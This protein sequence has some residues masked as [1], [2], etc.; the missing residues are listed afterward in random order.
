MRIGHLIEQQQ[1]TVGLLVQ[2]FAQPDVG[3]GIDV[4]DHALMRRV[5]RDNPAEIGDIAD[6]NRDIIRDFQRCESLAGDRYLLD[7]PVG[8]VERCFY[9]VPSPEFES[10]TGFLN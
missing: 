3:Q 6:H 9:R 10:A 5:A 1:R 8:I 7:H 4:G 2:Y